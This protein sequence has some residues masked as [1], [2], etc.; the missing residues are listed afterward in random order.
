[1]F[2]GQGSQYIGMGKEFYDS[3]PVAKE[4]FDKASEV[5]GLDIAK[6]CFEENDRINITEYTQICMLTEEVALNYACIGV[7]TAAIMYFIMAFLLK[8]FGTEKVMRFFPPIVT[9]PMVI[10]I[11]LTLS[12]SA[13]N[14]CSQNWLLS[15][16]AITVVIGS[17]IWGKGIIKIV[18]I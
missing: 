6:L 4:V 1:M 16:V 3:F 9:G 2:P 14:N 8:M 11:G 15:I 18:P 5:T 13:I 17:S 10:A 7:A 12:G